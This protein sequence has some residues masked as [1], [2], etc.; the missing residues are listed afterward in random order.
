MY[1][2][3]FQTEF[4]YLHWWGLSYSNIMNAE[5]EDESKICCVKNDKQM[6]NH[7]ILSHYTKKSYL[8]GVAPYK[9]VLTSYST[10]SQHIQPQNIKLPPPNLRVPSTKRSVSGSPAFFH[11]HFL[12]SDPKQLILVSSDQTT[13]FQC[14]N[15]QCSCAWAKSNLSLRWRVEKM[16]RFF[17]IM[18]FKPTDLGFLCMI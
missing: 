11:V 6:H 5:N 3:V 8:P 12:P 16:G 9:Q 18:N 4:F 1:L 7:L 10:P 14:S 13:F 2:K 17:L 15:V